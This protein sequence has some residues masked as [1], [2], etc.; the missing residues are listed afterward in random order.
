MYEITV[1]NISKRFLKNTLFKNINIRLQSGDSLA[2]TGYNGSGK[3]TFLKIISGFVTPTTGTVVFKQND[4]VI[5]QADMF[6]FI[7]YAAPY[8]DLIDDFTLSDNIHFYNRFKKFYENIGYDELIKIAFLNGAE[9][10]QVKNFSSGMK[11]RLKLSLA[12]LSDTPFLFLDE[13]L[14][15]L[16]AK[17]GRAHV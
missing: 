2:V 16:D 11:Q 13:P 14:S 3:S 15:N 10:K 1:E 8:I 7:A 5:E 12:F 6:R 17:I 9:N 4:S